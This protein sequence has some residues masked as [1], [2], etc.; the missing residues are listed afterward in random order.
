MEAPSSFHPRCRAGRRGQP[1]LT[2]HCW[3]AKIH[4][5]EWNLGFSNRLTLSQGGWSQVSGSWYSPSISSTEPGHP[6][7]RSLS[8]QL[9]G[10]S[11]KEESLSSQ[12]SC[13]THPQPGEGQSRQLLTEQHL[14]HQGKS[15]LEVILLDIF[16]G[17]PRITDIRRVLSSH[18]WYFLAEGQINPKLLL[19]VP[20]SH[21]LDLN[22]NI[23]TMEVSVVGGVELRC[24]SEESDQWEKENDY[25]SKILF[26]DNYF[27]HVKKVRD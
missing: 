19:L 18:F 2:S 3:E 17:N 1:K 6:N 11:V 12:V 7:H 5:T 8:K 27:Y 16:I 13:G 22:L 26:W 14:S 15:Y 25:A 21:F 24:Q 20:L 9:R 23:L 4:K 10:I